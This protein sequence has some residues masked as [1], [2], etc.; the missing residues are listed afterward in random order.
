MVAS[1]TLCWLIGRFCQLVRRVSEKN[2][3]TAPAVFIQKLSCDNLFLLFII[4][5]FVKQERE[6]R[7]KCQKNYLC[8]KFY[9][10]HGRKE[11]CI[12]RSLDICHTHLPTTLAL[13][14]NDVGSNNT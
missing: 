13:F 9:S 3:N 2:L 7:N 12:M 6:H 1:Y 11:V 5:I 4:F 14:K 10:V 8:R